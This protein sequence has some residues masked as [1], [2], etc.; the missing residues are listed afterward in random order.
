MAASSKD[1]LFHF[2]KLGSLSTP[3][4]FLGIILRPSPLL[5]ALG[6]NMNSVFLHWPSHGLW[7]STRWLHQRADSSWTQGGAICSQRIF[8]SGIDC[9]SLGICCWLIR[10][11][12]L[13]PKNQFI[14]LW[15]HD[16]ASDTVGHPWSTRCW[17]TVAIRANAMNYQWPLRSSKRSSSQAKAKA[18]AKP[19]S[20]DFRFL[21]LNRFSHAVCVRVLVIG[22][23]RGKTASQRV[24][25]RLNRMMRMEASTA[26]SP[27][28]RVRHAPPKIWRRR[29]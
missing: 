21:Y 18:I 24:V 13:F 3:Q 10:R 15:K 6:W 26:L 20:C 5:P 16:W 14:E 25:P 2:A 1:M 11:L 12:F 27:S 28:S 23:T 19:S 29:L 9:I 7:I 22:H 4:A 8:L 17:L